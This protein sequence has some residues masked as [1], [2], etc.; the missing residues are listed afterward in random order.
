MD[1]RPHC[2][3]GKP[4]LRCARRR[5]RRWLLGSIAAV[6]V[7]GAVA[8]PAVSGGGPG[9]IAVSASLAG[10]DRSGTGITCQVAVSFSPLPRAAY[11][12]ATVTRPDGATQAF[13]RVGP[14]SATLPVTYTRNGHYLVT[15]SAWSGA[16]RLG[17]SSSG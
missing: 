2:A 16:N 7:A 17:R 9:S 14:G 4:T 12:S 11:Y 8:A 3:N 1:S 13:G 15:I 5:R 6:L 10:C